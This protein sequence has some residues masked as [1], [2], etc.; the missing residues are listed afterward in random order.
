MNISQHA[1]LHR[2]PGI[3]VQ[4]DSSNTLRIRTP[5]G[6]IT[7][8]HH[9]L[10]VLNMFCEPRP[11]VAAL[12]LMRNHVTG[13]QDWIDL[14]S[15]IAQLHSAGVLR[16]VAEGGKQNADI[17]LDDSTHSYVA[18]LNDRVL[19]EK[20]LA[21]VQE[22]VRPGDIVIDVGA[23]VGLL[24]IAAARAGA[25]HVYAIETSDLGDVARDTI[26]ANGL[27]HCITVLPEIPAP[28]VLAG[29]ADV[30]ICQAAVQQ[31]LSAGN[32][33][34]LQEAQAQLLKPY[35]RILPAAVN[36]FGLPV[37]LPTHLLDMYTFT[38]HVVENWQSWYGIDLSSYI[39]ASSQSSH[40]FLASPNDARAWPVL[41][42]PLH[43]A[44]VDLAADAPLEI[45]VAA[46]VVATAPGVLNAVV[47]YTET[48][49]SPSVCLSL[50][51]AHAV[52]GECQV[53]IL[54][55][56]HELRPGDLFALHYSA[57]VADNLARVTVTGV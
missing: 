39:T 26:A 57:N 22:I 14:T 40:L 29:L 19:M 20:L 7:S 4:V 33:A 9:G 36:V 43:L 45:A 17:I 8:G 25:Q 34:V 18:Q 10:A 52:L 41:S 32:Y 47:V 13:L 1:I 44:T 11:L 55:Q 31:P 23:G 15:T 5:K 51:P 38:P 16:N 49:L 2:S 56:Q 54:D 42:A 28:S 53:W 21:A 30:L 37:T 35:G 6:V 46:P 48:A 50:N 12:S 27:S 3:V 24:S